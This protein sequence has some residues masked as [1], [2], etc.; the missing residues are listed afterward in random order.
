MAIQFVRAVLACALLSMLAAACSLGSPSPSS[1]PLGREVADRV[2]R[3][4]LEVAPE[5][6]RPKGDY[7]T[8][9]AIGNGEFVTAAH[10]IED[11][12]GSTGQ[13]ALLDA[14]GRRHPIEQIVRFSNE[15]DFAVIRS[16][17]APSG[18]PLTLNAMPPAVGDRL[19]FAGRKMGGGIEVRDARLQSITEGEYLE[20]PLLQFAGAV[21]RG[22]SGG[23]LFD[24]SGAVRG[25][26]SI[27][28]PE[29]RWGKATSIRALTDAE[30]TKS[31]LSPYALISALGVRASR[32]LLYSVELPENVSY[33]EFAAALIKARHRLYRKALFDPDDPPEADFV[34]LGPQAGPICAMLNGKPCTDTPSGARP[35]QLW[36]FAPE[37]LEPPLAQAIHPDR[38]GTYNIHGAILIRDALS[39]K[40]VASLNDN[41]GMHLRLARK[42]FD[43]AMVRTSLN[44]DYE[45]L[46]AARVESPTSERYRDTHN[47]DWIAR[48]WKLEDE[49]FSIVSLGRETDDKRG[50]I[51]LACV[52]RMSRV[53]GASVLLKYVANFTLARTEEISE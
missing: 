42:S 23:P 38:P 46:L 51:T 35:A 45:P 33:E 32:N 40:P 34:L 5:E 2:I 16:R 39:S 53:D 20:P 36:R 14:Q 11:F 48:T 10:V 1:P 37:Y 13:P 52:V 24:S 50:H 31:Q 4:T 9:F 3:A 29:N 6:R 25:V 8:G 49:D 17:G 26:V 43:D 30:P 44:T 19:W 7:G 12:I 41:P 27:G 21:E 22:F 47:R 28:S 18:E 15:D